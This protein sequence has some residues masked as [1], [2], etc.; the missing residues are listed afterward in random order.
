MP[1]IAR[2]RTTVYLQ[3]ANGDQAEA[4]RYADDCERMMKDSLA[5]AERAYLRAF[6]AGATLPPD[7]EAVS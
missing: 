4:N 5:M 6:G 1:V 7:P 3:D 2:N